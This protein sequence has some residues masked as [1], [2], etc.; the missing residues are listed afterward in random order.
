MRMLMVGAGSCQ[1]SGI[2]RL[3]AMGIEVVAADYNERTPGKEMADFAVLADAFDA[4]A[5]AKTA[6]DYAVDGIMTMGT[7]Q[8][9]LSVMRSANALGLSAS[10]SDET[11]L[12][13]TNK[14]YMK[15]RFTAFDIP[16]VPYQI[17]TRPDEPIAIKGPYVTKPF[18]SQGQRGIFLLKEPGAVRS[19][20]EKVLRY[21]REK[22]IL[23]ESFYPSDEVTVS[24]WVS[25]ARVHVLTLT[26]RVTFDPEAHIGVCVA[27]EYPSIYAESHGEEIL[28]LTERICKVFGIEDGPIYFQMLIGSEGICVNE[29]ACRLGGAYEDISIPWA[30]GVDVLDLQIK[31]AL[32]IKEAFSALNPYCG[33]G[34]SLHVPKKYFS[35]QLFFCRPGKI[36]EMPTLESIE[37]LPFV[38]SAGYNIK[39]GD[40]MESIENASQ[41]VGFAVVVGASETEIQKNIDLFYEKMAIK[42]SQGEN[43]VIKRHRNR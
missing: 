5:I 20:F 19:H 16:T 13:V 6:A 11:A 3:K 43:L 42:N 25:D 41:R 27:H 8:P 37:A 12:W 14:K 9:V 22:E 17:L 7:D 2:K 34:L 24:G 10:L 32:G 18:D 38:V 33:S 35:T 26:D 39:A 31:T 40:D 28:A 29:I 1:I 36:E 30:T 23:I 15:Q 4:G 21:S